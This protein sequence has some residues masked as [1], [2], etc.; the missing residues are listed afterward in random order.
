MNAEHS[1]SFGDHL[2]LWRQGR[3]LSQLSLSGLTGVS[4][5][6]LST[7][8]TDKA[9]PSR[10]MV[11]A[12]CDALDV[13]ARAR[14]DML[15]AADYVPTSASTPPDEAS[16][17][18]SRDS[19]AHL[20]KAHDPVPSVLVDRLWNVHDYNSGF[21][22]LICQFGEVDD[23]LSRVAFDGRPNLLKLFYLAAGICSHVSNGSQIG[24]QALARLMLQSLQAPGDT[25]LAALRDDLQTLGEAPGEWWELPADTPSEIGEL[26]LT[27]DGVRLR[28][29]VLVSAFGALTEDNDLGWRIVTYLPLDAATRTSFHMAE[30]TPAM[31]PAD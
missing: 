7:L 6:Y 21:G 5:R 25:Q 23:I 3:G 2:R 17:A 10:A 14:A 20:L 13:P 11:T 1:G 22:Q 30:T 28:L 12:L 26:V 15:M 18:A 27:R 16:I 4:Q 8:E 24:R 29:A 31:T 19:L 9:H